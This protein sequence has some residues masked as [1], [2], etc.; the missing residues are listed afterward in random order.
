MFSSK[1][2]DG[3]NEKKPEV[4]QLFVVVPPVLKHR[5]EARISVGEIRQLVNHRY[6][7]FIRPSR[8]ICRQKLQI[9]VRRPKLIGYELLGESLTYDVGQCLELQRQ[10]ASCRSVIRMRSLVESVCQ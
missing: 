1:E 3:S 2:T 6:G 4:R 8:G 5:K 7:W 10:S 9:F